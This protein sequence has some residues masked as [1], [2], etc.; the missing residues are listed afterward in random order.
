MI[1]LYLVRH[2][3][4]PANLTKQ[5]S[6]QKI[7][8]SLTEKGRLQARQ[9]A[10][11]FSNKHIDAIYSSPLKRA[12]ESA[13]IIAQMLSLPVIILE[14]FREVN[15]GLF[16]D[17]PASLKNW[18]L[19]NEILS[20]WINGHPQ[21]FFPGGENFLI[22]KQRMFTGLEK[23]LAG[24]IDQKIIIV[25]HGGLFTLTLKEY[26]P[27]VDTTILMGAENHNCSISEI[28]IENQDGKI[29]GELIEWAFT[30]HLSGM[31]AELVSGIPESMRIKSINPN[32]LP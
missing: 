28:L 16:E 1:H 14:E 9:T 22:L 21:R 4:N 17:L 7:D 12:N 18:E 29:K 32:K 30:G 27:D 31:A 23:A 5:F 20:G 2:G 25:G 6:C 19:H 13:A 3:E 8:Y 11:F 26:C 24:R 15:V 10:Q